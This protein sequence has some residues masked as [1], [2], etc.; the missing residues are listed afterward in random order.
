MTAC[1]LPTYL[2]LA[3]LMGLR[4]L[5]SDH[6]PAWQGNQGWGPTAG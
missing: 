4:R 6:V 1:G 5:M 2:E 3:R